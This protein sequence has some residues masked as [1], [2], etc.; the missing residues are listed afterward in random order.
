[1]LRQDLEKEG[2]EDLTQLEDIHEASVLWN[3]RNRY[4]ASQF[5][6]YI[7]SIL[8][9]IN[10][11][12]MHPNLYG[13]EMAKKYSN[14]TLGQLPPHLFA[15]GK[16]AYSALVNQKQNQTIVV[17]GESG[18]GKTECSKLIMQYL[19]AV[20][21]GGGISSNKIA[22]QILEASPLLESFGNAKTTK[23]DNSSRFG[24]YLEVYFKS[25]SIIG[26]KITQY[27]LEKSR[28]VTQLP[29][30][31]N[32]HIFYELLGGLNE[33][34]RSK[35][36]L[37]EAD[38][39]FYLNQGSSDCAPN[40]SCKEWSSL[41]GSMQVLGFTD[42]EREGI[43]RVLASVLHIGNVYFHRR[44]LRNSMEGVELGSDGAECK[45]ASHL[46]DVS[47]EDLIRS[48]KTR[49]TETRNELLYTP[50]TIDQA[51]DARDA[52][53]KAVYSGLFN[54]IVSR[55]N[56]I[57][58]KGGTH[59]AQRIS[60]LDIFG[61]ES[62]EE[63]SFEQLCINYANESLQLF[64]NK[65]VFKM[66]Q[67]EYAK[68]RLEWE[69]M[70]WEDNLPIIHLLA[71]KPVGIFH[72]LDDESNFPRASDMS[73]LE[74]CHYNHALNEI[75]SRPRVG[76]NEFGITHHSSGL[77]WYNVEGFLEK[78]RDSLRPEVLALLSSSSLP[79][80]Q[81]MSKQMR[82]Q[83]E[84]KNLPR[85][86]NGRFIT[87]KP[88][89]PTVSARFS[90]SLQ[91]L[92]TSM[93]K[94]NPWFVRT[95]RPN[96]T[97][98][99]K[100]VDMSCLLSQVRSLGV[101]SSV[102]IRKKGYPVRL[103]FQHFVER[104]RFLLKRPIS[105]GTPYRELCRQV[106][107]SFPSN[108]EHD[109]QLGA[110]R[111]FL[112]ES[113]HRK[114]ER[115]RNQRLHRAAIIIQ[116]NARS[117][118]LKK[119]GQSQQKSAIMIQ[120]V[121]RGY[122]QRKRYQNMR[123]GIVKLQALYRGGKERKRYERVK[124]EMRRMKEAK[125]IRE[126]AVHR[127]P[128]KA[129]VTEKSSIVHLDV[130]AEL[131]FI[132]SKLD[133]WVQIHGDRNLVKVVGTVPGPPISAELPMELDQFGL[134]KFS[135]VYCNGI[136][137]HPRKDPITTPFLTRTAARDKDFQ[138]ALSIFKLILRWIGDSSL[139][140][141]KDKVLA[142]YIVNKGLSSRSLR[143][144]ILVQLCN[145][146]Y[147]VEESQA[148]RIWHL[149]S[150]CL[151]TFQPGAAFSKYLM[152]F[153]IDNA[154]LTQREL[155]LK[156]LLRST[157]QSVRL[158]PP[159]YLEWRA[160]KQSDVAVGLTLPDGKLQTVAID[161]WTTCEEAASLS[162]ALIPGFQ[163]QGWTVV[164][165][166]MDAVT[167]SCGLDYLLDFIGEKELCPAFPSVKNDLL[168]ISRN[169]PLTPLRSPK[170]PNSPMEIEPLK[171]PINPPP[172]PP[173]QGKIKYEKAEREVQYT[174]ND[175]PMMHRKTS[176]DLLSRSS[177]L[178]E[179]YFETDKSRSR[180]LDDLMNSDT[181][182]SQPE[183]VEVKQ[184]LN[185]LGLSG[186]RLNDRYHSAERLVPMKQPV[187]KF[188]KVPYTGK[189]TSSIHSNKYSDRPDHMFRSSGMSDTSE[190]PS[191]ASHVR[192]VRVPSQ[193]SDVDQFLD[194][195][196]SPVLD[197]NLDEL[198]DARSLAASIRGNGLSSYDE[199]PMLDDEVAMLQDTNYL[200]RAIKGGIDEDEP[201]NLIPDA[202]LEEYITE[203]F[204]PIFLNENICNL[205]EKHELADTIR[206]GGSGANVTEEPGSYQQQA[207]RAF[208]ESAMEQNIKI[209][210]QLIAQNEA[211][212]TLLCQQDE[213]GSN[214]TSQTT[215]PTGGHHPQG[216][217]KTMFKF[218]SENNY[219]EMR[220]D[221]NGH[222][223]NPPP[224]PPMP[225]P[226]IESDPFQ[227]PFMDPYGKLNISEISEGEKII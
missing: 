7:G 25:G 35:Y 33:T 109:F 133:G 1:M 132:F 71:K 168:R 203:L 131:A 98:Q 219:K 51:L 217:L 92:L 106:L 159:T 137:L 84:E 10:P 152:K 102:N 116:R 141:N 12:M 104:Y 129:H 44:Q 225:P 31:R 41:Q 45:W 113:L 85:G 108:N 160:A 167:D 87:M 183:V 80:V 75:Y 9:S 170:S 122:V 81:E 144:E 82:A 2:V 195:L 110:A 171:R 97:K 100:K 52:F 3:L 38:K 124:H 11:Y 103:R 94:S 158:Y 213:N 214:P 216:Q 156:K 154:P 48:L 67:A 55:I 145:Q 146:V 83:R 57:I 222:F 62:L 74:K 111:V 150:H 65:H 21:P 50:L 93:S 72:L 99:P 184:P 18:S 60:I 190:T 215:S 173:Q 88:R 125:Q 61:F 59:D 174:R 169:S 47:S 178:N 24:K 42:Q 20:V 101:L 121:M 198:S 66:E 23:N 164:L 209:Q 37:L 6:T 155:L 186:S 138:D 77:V 218:T 134:G 56:S 46:L 175:A 70:E 43:N 204:Q 201:D 221:N 127:A 63:N 226:L 64:F 223:S 17:S 194:D 130:P 123:T 49:L 68:E 187:P 107:D 34:E 114:L 120:K 53:A 210:Q 118:L 212:Q 39:Y 220:V 199:A 32:Y 22:E 200:C 224:P 115:G 13:L 36:G 205:A 27:L 119:K 29:D 4:E 188:L 196:F 157:S 191:L 189:R 181:E 117:V 28:I 182:P 58:H 211:L 193:A 139:D 5:Y 140:A 96:D 15:I 172:A 86:S 179:R 105:R 142:D 161:A 69:P 207:Q 192:R 206:G 90:D 54:W 112:R 180:S 40:G 128:P 162:L 73:F 176:I 166:D 91:R 149:M 79:V 197:S 143:D 147:G 95:I 76:A 153:I 16:A 177:A 165:D 148:T 136:Q 19:A 89:T 8:I 135:S 14:S 26:A 227:R 78:N 202:S 163:T 208:L 151:S 185:E 126:R 30:E